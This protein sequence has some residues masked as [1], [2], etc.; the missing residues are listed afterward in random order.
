MSFFSV[1]TGVLLVNLGSPDA[2][3]DK[4]VRKYLKQFLNDKRVIHEDNMPHWLWWFILNVFILPARPKK[5]AK[6]YQK[7]WNSFGKGSPLVAIS[8][9]QALALENYFQN[10]NVE[11]A[12]AMRYGNPSIAH[13]MNELLAKDVEKIIVLPLFPQY[14]KTTT[15]SVF[16]EIRELKILKK[17]PQIQ[18]INNYHDHPA[19]IDALKQ[20]I[21]NYWDT[22]GKADKLIISYHGLPQKYVDKGDIY[23]QQCETTTKLLVAALNLSSE[24]YLHCYQSRF[25]RQ[26]WLQPYLDKQLKAMPAA[27]IKNVQVI[28]PGFAADCLETLE[29]IEHENREYFMQAGGQ[30]YNYIPALN[31]SPEHIS[32]LLAIIKQ[33]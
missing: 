6:L 17:L 25:G 18:L 9:K 4:A 22:H 3:N 23:P 28:C 31:H 30:Q 5:S 1:K 13:G 2:A 32:S 15:E 29:E 7:V 11:I 12:L 20:S 8:K 33:S 19:Y 10:S 14:S 27:G 26:V 24:Q 16:D 21:L